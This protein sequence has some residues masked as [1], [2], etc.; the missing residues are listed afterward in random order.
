MRK[1]GGEMTKYRC[2]HCG[3]VLRR[4]SMKQWLKSYCSTACMIAHLQRLPEDLEPKGHVTEMDLK[5]AG[6]KR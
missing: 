3:K 1:K 4:R 2:V 5:K 6:I